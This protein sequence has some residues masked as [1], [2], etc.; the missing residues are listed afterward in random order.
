[1]TD[2]SPSRRLHG[3]AAAPGVAVGRAYVVERRRVSVTRRHLEPPEVEPEVLRLRGAI[4]AAR[5][6]LQN[7]QK[8]LAPEASE[9]SLILD[10]HL[11]MLDDVLLVEQTERAIREEF[12]NAEWA[13]RRT[14]ER[15]KELFD[16]ADDDY[17]RERRS[18]VDFVGE[19]VLRHLAGSPTEIARPRDLHG[20]IVLVA[21]ELSPA[22]TAA[23]GRSEVIA[24]VTDVGSATSHTAIMA[25]ALSLPAVVGAGDATRTIANGDLLVVDGL[26]GVVTV[27]PTDFEA[28]TATDRGERYIAFARQL[29]S[30]RDRPARTGDGVPIHLRANIELPAEAAVAIDH[31]AEGIGLYRTEFLYIDRREPPTEDEQYETFSR[32]VRTMAPKPVTLRTFDLGGDKFTTALRLP[33]EMNPALGLR[34]VR[35]A[36]REREVFRAQL[37]AMLRAASHGAVRIMIPMVTT[38]GEL[39]E[40]RSEL[41][42]ARQELHFRGVE[43]PEVPLGIMVETP[44]A[45]FVAEH[46]AAECAFFSVGTNDL[47]QYALAIDR[48]NEHVAH[49]ARSL[50][51]A[52]LR[53]LSAVIGAGRRAKIPVALCGAMAA[54]LMALP[55]LLGLG[56]HELS[57]EPTAVPEIKEA[58]G[59]LSYRDCEALVDR[60]W[61]LTTAAEVEDAVHQSV[62]A[63]FSDLL[64]AGGAT[65]VTE[66][67]TFLLPDL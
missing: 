66:T 11:L 1:M 23:L 57:V 52:I 4:G 58:L 51:P 40:A 22:D 29:R 48:G 32:I 62:G 12:I 46:L 26:R 56:F 34:A 65:P 37:R 17:F 14:V 67:G 38:V 47:M 6:Q 20:P 31:G 30:N 39:R 19:R 35:L 18:D 59:R 28:A 16:Q 5:A 36:L 3:S 45:V 13:L 7:I 27:Q 49:L 25:R 44:A 61:G 24:F 42:I 15:I 55:V 43:V 60:L 53:A 33:R 21:H 8:K 54:E 41:E 10:A 9:H 64:A 63:L 2:P 50:D